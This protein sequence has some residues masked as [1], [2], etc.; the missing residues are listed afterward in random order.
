MPQHTIQMLVQEDFGKALQYSF[1]KVHRNG[2]T[3]EP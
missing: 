3:P 2:I 1:V